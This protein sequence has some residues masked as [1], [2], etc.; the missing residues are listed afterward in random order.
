MTETER[1]RTPGEQTALLTAGGADGGRPDQDL[2]GPVLV[3]TSFYTARLPVGGMTVGEI[4]R[5]FSDRLDIDPQATPVLDGQTIRDDS[6]VVRPHQT[7]SFIRH[8]GEK[9]AQAHGG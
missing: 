6:T 4:R 7:L 3:T 1:T 2:A 9:G 8:A 5:N